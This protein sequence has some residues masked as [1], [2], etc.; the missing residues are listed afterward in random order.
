MSDFHTPPDPFM[1]ASGDGNPAVKFEQVGDTVTGVITAITERNDTK[2]DGTINTWAD[3]S[4][5]K[6]WV[7]TLDTDGTPRSLFVRGNMVRAIR[8]AAQAAS[9]PTL[10]G[11]QLTVQHHDMGEKKPGRF[12]AKLYRAKVEPAP[13]Q[14]AAAATPW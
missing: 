2:P 5:V 12:P 6:M 4:P 13:A 8:E 7:F 10:I 1:A 11:Q 9:V 14:T 3:G